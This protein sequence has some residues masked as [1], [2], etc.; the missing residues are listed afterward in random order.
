MTNRGRRKEFV[1]HYKENPP[2][3]G[4]YRVVNARTGKALIGSTT[5]LESIFA[6]LRFARITGSGSALDMRLKD[7]V[8]KYGIDAFDVEVIE[9]LERRPEMSDTQIRDELKLLEA[10]CREQY[11]ENAL[12]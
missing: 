10:L 11:D 8:R 6:K 5:N 3:A 7:D 9:V 12:Y 1:S 4:V 2:E